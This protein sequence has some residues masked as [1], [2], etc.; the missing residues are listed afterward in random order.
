[1]VKI[2][3]KN[4]ALSDLN[5]A[6][7]PGETYQHPKQMHR[8]NQGGKKRVMNNLPR[9]EKGFRFNK[10]EGMEKA[11]VR[12]GTPPK[13]TRIV[14]SMIRG[15]LNRVILSFSLSGEYK[16]MDGIDQGDAISP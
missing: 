16:V 13:L 10:Q 6:G 8:N 2:L 15:R 12:I 5:W 1:M 7:L 3:I 9:H 4:Q 14:G 11:L